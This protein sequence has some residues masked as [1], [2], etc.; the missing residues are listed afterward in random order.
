MGQT[1]VTVGAY[2]RYAQATGKPMLPNK[3]NHGRLVNGAAGNDTLP[4][5][6]MTWKEAPGY[7]GWAGM[8]L[9][10]EAEWEYAA[11]VG[12]TGA[13]YGRLDDIAWYVGNSGSQRLDSIAI[14]NTEWRKYAQR[15]YDNGNTAH[16]IGLKR[17]NGYGLYD[18][19]GNVRQWTADWYGNEDRER[20]LRGG[21]YR[22]DPHN[23]RV[24]LGLGIA[25]GGRSYNFRCVGE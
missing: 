24:S 21:S 18:M 6:A 5:V 16:A 3:D 17:P 4:A 19:L 1:P 8:R 9:P 7:C 14:W 11:R 23:L 2:R 25:P 20:A 13:R 10:T 12:T 22:D 15:L